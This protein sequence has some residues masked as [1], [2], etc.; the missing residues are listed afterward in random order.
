[1][2]YL[3]N[4]NYKGNVM[5]FSPSPIYCPIDSSDYKDMDKSPKP[6]PQEEKVNAVAQ[7]T[8]SYLKELISIGVAFTAVVVS[9]LATPSFL[10]VSLGILGIV[11][12][13]SFDSISSK[14]NTRITV[15]EYRHCYDQI[16]DWIKR[17]E[18]D[19][20]IENYELVAQEISDGKPYYDI[21]GYFA[22][23]TIDY[24]DNR[25]QVI[26]T[27]H[28]NMIYQR[29]RSLCILG[30]HPDKEPLKRNFAN[31]LWDALH[32]RCDAIKHFIDELESGKKCIKG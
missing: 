4:F 10:A 22:S 19:G 30:K 28:Y 6:L 18:E 12:Y 29:A 9:A 5:E 23:K 21:P 7:P 14:R 31:H 25:R 11:V 26:F 15:E 24:R 17:L 16:Q 20:S 27:L 8:F 3:N 1:M 13:Y 2:I 32:N